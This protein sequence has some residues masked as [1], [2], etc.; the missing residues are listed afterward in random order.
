M[1]YDRKMLELQAE[2]EHPFRYQLKETEAF[3]TS[4]RT[5]QLECEKLQK[6][7][8]REKEAVTTLETRYCK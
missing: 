1:Y 3:K 8:S 4:Q 5:L 6:S 7:Y 2:V